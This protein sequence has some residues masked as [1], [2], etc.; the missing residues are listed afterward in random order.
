[1][2]LVV[3][4]KNER[5]SRRRLWDI[6][7][8]CFSFSMYSAT[9]LLTMANISISLLQGSNPQ[10]QQNILYLK[11]RRDT[12]L[13]SCS[14]KRMYSLVTFER[15][16]R[17]RLR[18]ESLA[19]RSMC[20][21][22]A[23]YGKGLAELA[24]AGRERRNNVVRHTFATIPRSELSIYK[25]TESLPCFR[26]RH[27]ESELGNSRVTALRYV[28]R[29]IYGGGGVLRRHL[30]DRERASALDSRFAT[31]SIVDIC[32]DRRLLRKPYESKNVFLR[33]RDQSKEVGPPFRFV[34]TNDLERLSKSITFLDHTENLPRPVRQ[35]DWTGDRLRL[36]TAPAHND[37]HDVN[38]QRTAP[39]LRAAS[40]L[41]MRE[42]T[43][44][45]LR[46][47]E[48]KKTQQTPWN[49]NTMRPSTFFTSLQDTTHRS[50]KLPHQ[51]LRD[52]G[53]DDSLGGA[54]WRTC[55]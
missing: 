35:K 47:E 24:E 13:P 18:R 53:A 38:G 20:D 36:V 43:S 50:H 9:S 7:I 44:T 4:E 54:S 22:R 40:P 48:Q 6:D 10:G 25:S 19:R 27:I 3:L 52:V 23:I 1:M 33:S 8:L 51:S 42:D 45:P 2:S 34:E 49:N 39:S 28:P 16:E 26:E 29:A 31:V 12:F 37:T 21:R 5:E 14:S 41:G 15:E 11:M 55:R 46:R 30:E 32:R 17:R